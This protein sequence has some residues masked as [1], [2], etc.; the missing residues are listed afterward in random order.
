MATCSRHWTPIVFSMVL[1]VGALPTVTVGASRADQTTIE[2][3]DRQTTELS[4]IERAQAAEWGLSPIEWRRYQT[5][6]EGV[7]GHIS[8][9]TLSPIE[10]LGIHARDDAERR[11]YAEQWAIVMREDAERILA[12]QQAY[13]AAMQRLFPHEALID[14]ARLPK[15]STEPPLL[16]TD[17][18]LL[19]VRPECRACEAIL[20]RLLSRRDA[21]AG[22]DIYVSGVD[23]EEAV[24]S[25][26]AAHGIEPGWVQTRQV[27]LNLEAGILAELVEGERMLPVVLRRR[28]ESVTRLPG[29]AL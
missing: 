10:A 24:R 19:F 4:S 28:G 20:D 21:V 27:T 13:D 12:F 25:W 29:S 23:G 2:H 26:A 5:L 18:I 6:L 15:R 1:V 11:R 17:R 8:P 3:S 7:R 16:A 9:S 14:V 22:I